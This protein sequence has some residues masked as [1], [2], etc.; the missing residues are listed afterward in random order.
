MR[1]LKLLYQKTYKYE[2]VNARLM[3]NHAFDDTTF[4]YDGKV[5]KSFN[6]NDE[7]IKD[8]CSFD[9]VIAMEYVQ[10]NDCLC[11]AT[12]SGEIITYNFM[13]NECETVGLINDG[14]EC[15]SWSPDQELVIFVSK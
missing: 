8:L 14:I 6:H 15:M 2:I 5:V 1:N 13:N 11:L 7:E 3:T 4:I 12:S 10:L 9:D